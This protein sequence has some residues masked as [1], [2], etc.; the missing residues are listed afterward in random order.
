MKTYKKGV[1]NKLS[2]NFNSIEFDCHGVGC[3]KETKIDE[4]LVEYLQKIREHF[5]KPIYISSAYRCATHN[6]N[7]GGATG[8]YHTKGQAADIYIDG[9]APAEIAKYAESIGILG[10][11]LYETA[12][13]GYFVHVDTRTTKSFWYG[14]KQAYRATFG[15]NASK[16]EASEQK[17][18]TSFLKK[19]DSGEEVKKMQ[20][21]L[22]NLGYRFGKIDAAF[23]ANTEKALVSFQGDNDLTKDGLY[24]K[25]TEKVLESAKYT[26]G[27]VIASA[28]NVRASGSM[29]APVRSVLEKGKKIILVSEKE[30]WG[31]LINGAGYV[32]LDY[33]KKI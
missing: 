22:Y 21:L 4:K 19:G 1:K 25:E 11:G 2:V 30:G 15:G 6:K 17:K 9:V 18:T 13:D 12:A 32:S 20:E 26:E 8:S 28:L 10:I 29:S 3:C 33:I 5:N 24:G 7:V 27:E 16:T 14:Q 31:R 23:G